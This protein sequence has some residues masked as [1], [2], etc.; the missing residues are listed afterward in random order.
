MYDEKRKD[1]GRNSMVEK[2][3]FKNKNVTWID[4]PD[5][6]HMKKKTENSLVTI[7]HK[8][9][10]GLPGQIFSDA[11]ILA[12]KKSTQEIPHSMGVYQKRK[13]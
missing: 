7:W 11:E 10:A 4:V 2:T 6:E 1:D 12:L 8:G 9:C 3:E 13:I 5:C